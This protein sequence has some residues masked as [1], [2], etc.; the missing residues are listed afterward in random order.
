M[1]TL[2]SLLSQREKASL[3]GKPTPSNL[4]TYPQGATE[5]GL[6]NVARVFMKCPKI[7]FIENHD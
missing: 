3:G 7:F 6:E 2:I 4:R 1:L 5:N